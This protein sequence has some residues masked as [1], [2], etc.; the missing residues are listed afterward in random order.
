M[1]T[2]AP[3]WSDFTTQ[4]PQFADPTFNALGPIQL[5]ISTR[6]LSLAVWGSFYSDG[7]M[8]DCAHNLTLMQM[9]TNGGANGG[10]QM[11]IGPISST[12]VAGTSTSFNTPA[13]TGKANSVDWYNKTI[14]GQQF[15]R[16]RSAVCDMGV[17]G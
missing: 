7:I 3:T 1:N 11:A 12:S 5:G 9:T 2:V 16:L 10:V 4:Y 17:L 6:M 15:L 8:L 13:S 14:F